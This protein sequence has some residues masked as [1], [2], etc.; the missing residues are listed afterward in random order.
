M[1]NQGT[2]NKVTKDSFGILKLCCS[3]SRKFL[4]AVC[5][6]NRRAA[7]TPLQRATGSGEISPKHSRIEPLNRCGRLS[8]WPRSADLEIGD[9]RSS[10]CQAGWETCATGGVQ[11]Q[12]GLHPP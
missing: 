3:F 6:G 1:N 12:G 9:S 4:D 10:A 2:K 11:G 5:D 7:F 8:G